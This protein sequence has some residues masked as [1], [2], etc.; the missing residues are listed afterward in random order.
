[1]T[2]R[3]PEQK[4]DLEGP[5]YQFDAKSGTGRPGF[6]GR[7]LLIEDKCTGC[8]LCA[9]ACDGIAVAI[10]MQEV[11]LDRPHNKK[12]IW[13][14]VD[15]GR[16]VYCGLCVDS[17]TYVQTNLGF[18]PISQIQVGQMVLT[19]AGTYKPVTKVWDMTYTGPLYKIYVYGKPE[20]LVCTKDHRILA[21]SRPRGNRK[22]GRLLKT[23]E[24]LLMILPEGLKAGDYLVNPIV[25]KTVGVDRYEA[26]IPFGPGNRT[27]H[28]VLEAN[29][30][31]FRLIGYFIAEGSCDEYSVRFS[32]HKNE[33]TISKDID[34]L[35]KEFFGK[36]CTVAHL[37]GNRV[38][39]VLHSV[40]AVKFFSQFGRGAENK[41]ITDWVFHSERSKLLELMKGIWLGDGCRVQQPRQKYINFR[42]SSRVLAFQEQSIL[43]MLGIVGLIEREDQEER[44][45][46]YHV[47]AFGR[48]AVRLANLWKVEF[49]Y[50]P[51][52]FVDKF[53]LTCDYV[54]LPIR[55]IERLDVAN[56]RVMDVTVQEDHTFAPLGL[57]T[58]NCVDA[59]PFDAL[60]MT[61]HYEMAAYDRASLKYTPEMLFRPPRPTGTYKAKI[62]PKKGNV[63]HG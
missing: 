7:H 27:K 13:P 12:N 38:N 6:K 61:N 41:K 52:K 58:S 17:E 51:T 50:H 28:L 32:L 43:A 42:T 44:L 19:H 1:M 21:V 20:P 48:W 63:T 36:G 45:P 5:G 29:Q 14:A 3:Y 62:D 54:Y 26:D 59:C 56:Y 15:Y 35:S 47:N 40:L 10:E 60:V 8:Q 37:G 2:L 16:C 9:I 53:H 34:S 39:V 23:L 49:D 30:N 31:L 22:D 55:R 11:K 57:A 46:S 18:T 24:P 25:K 4:L 33:T